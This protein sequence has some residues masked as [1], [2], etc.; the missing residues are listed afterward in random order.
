MCDVV[1]RLDRT[2]EP[3]PRPPWSPLRRRRAAA[4]RHEPHTPGGTGAIPEGGEETPQE[5]ASLYPAHTPAHTAAVRKLPETLT[6]EHA[7]AAAGARIVFPQEHRPLPAESP[8]V[9]SPRVSAGCGG[10]HFVCAHGPRVPTSGSP[11]GVLPWSPASITA[12]TAPAHPTS[13][14]TS[15]PATPARYSPRAHRQHTP[16]P[17]RSPL[18]SSDIRQ[19]DTYYFRLPVCDGARNSDRLPRRDSASTPRQGGR[20]LPECA[21]IPRTATARR[22]AQTGGGKGAGCSVGARSRF[23]PHPP[24]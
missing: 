3:G 19:P 14:T 6:R 22:P 8:E 1:R 12:A 16:P 7:A 10:H 11:E 23:L 4:A 17:A 15:P 2:P 9:L 5:G 13:C 21:R 20:T 18:T 24:R